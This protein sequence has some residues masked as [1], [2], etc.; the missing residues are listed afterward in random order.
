METVL[1]TPLIT[2]KF[3]EKGN[4]TKVNPLRICCHE[5]S[6][7]PFVFSKALDDCC[8]EAEKIRAKMN[9]ALWNDLE[10]LFLYYS[11]I[12][13]GLPSTGAFRDSLLSCMKEGYII[14]RVKRLY[15]YILENKHLVSSEFDP[16]S[17]IELQ[18]FFDESNRNTWIVGKRA[19]GAVEPVF[20]SHVKSDS[21]RFELMRKLKK[22]KPG[23]IIEHDDLEKCRN[24]VGFTKKNGLLEAFFE[25]DPSG[26][27]CNIYRGST[28]RLSA[29]DASICLKMMRV[30][31][32]LYPHK[33]PPLI[34][35]S[36]FNK[37][38]KIKHKANLANTRHGGKVPLLLRG[39]MTCSDC[40]C[41]IIGDVK[42][43]GR[44]TYYSCTNGKG[45]C[46]KEWVPEKELVAPML[47]YLERIQLSDDLIEK[48][49][50]LSKEI[51]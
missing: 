26:K 39:L 28:V 20:L 51:I 46:K 30:K 15:N 33:Y 7:G 48:N 8:R 40:G 35:E 12:E 6:L 23:N 32:K 31:G 14:E 11:W 17:I 2:A 19:K 27:G 21:G 34:N 45:I 18:L 1:F 22:A 47:D 37:C 5:Y 9:T 41:R 38:Q 49:S 13:G 24:R 43:K 4:E 50:G 10:E 44:Y 3:D 16:R 25:K 36:L 42:K 29:E